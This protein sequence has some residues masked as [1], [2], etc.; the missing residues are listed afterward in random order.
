[1]TADSRSQSISW[2]R[3]P[4]DRDVLQGL[5]RRSDFKGLLQAGG[6][7]ALITL[8][9]A[10]AW[11]FQDRPLLL[12]TALF[13]HGTFYVFLLNATHE[14]CHGTVFKSHFLNRFFL[15]FFSFLCWRDHVGFW[16]SHAEHHKHTL[17]PPEDMEVVLPLKLT[18]RNF[19]TVAVIDL[20]FFWNTIKQVCAH[21]RGKVK[22]EWEN[23]LFPTEALEKRRRLTNA[24]RFMLT[25]HLCIIAVGV[26]L[27]IW[28]L[29]VLVTFGAF[30]GQWL[31]F[32]C[33]QLQHIGLVDEVADFRLCCRTV[34]LSPF[35][36]FL[37]WHMNYHTDHHM[38]PSVPCYNLGKL[39]RQSRHDLPSFPRGLIA[40]WREIIDILKRQKLD[41]SYQ[42]VPRLPI[43]TSKPDLST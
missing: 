5:H 40:A 13:V 22:G 32:L 4:V 25:G 7:L 38:Y 9:G 39:H 16:A 24:A 37:Y 11:Y 3:S 34:I 23:H 41:P 21:S 35:V 18:L 28:I 31:R 8:T 14:L 29:P 42:F 1:M 20:W 10:V 6:H 12:I 17:H 33:N 36:R 2:Y 26:Y 43:P 27:E 30:Y 15:R 19:L